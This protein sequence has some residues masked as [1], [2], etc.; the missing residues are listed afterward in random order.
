MQIE[1]DRD[2][3]CPEHAHHLRR[4]P[5]RLSGDGGIRSTPSTRRGVVV[6]HLLIVRAVADAVVDV[7]LD[8]GGAAS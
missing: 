8:V 2:S 3:G 1:V 5:G 7:L 6:V 4:W